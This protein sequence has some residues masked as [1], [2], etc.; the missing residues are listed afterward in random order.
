MDNG[1][2]LM[3]AGQ[4]IGWDQSGATGSYGTPATQAFFA[5]YLHATYVADGAAA[6]NQVLFEDADAVFGLVGNTTIIDAFA[7][8]TYPDQITPIAPA[9]PIMRYSPTKIGGLRCETGGYKLVYFG[10]G[11]E[12]VASPA[13]AELM[14]QASHDWFYGL[15]SVEE[16][17]ALMNNLGQAY[18]SPA[19]DVVNIPVGAHSGAATLEV[20]DATGRMVMSEGVTTQNSIVTLNTAALHS[21]VYSARLRTNEG[22][23]VARTFQV[24]R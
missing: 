2:N 17:D 4:D 9:V 23:G 22:A 19:S 8:N 16:F 6:D 24:A 3:I 14:V 5:D 18:P 7:G 11:P 15:V 20:F 12:Q 13:I 10:I 21:G 1:G